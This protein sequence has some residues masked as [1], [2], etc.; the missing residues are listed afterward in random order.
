MLF[1]GSAS[2]LGAGD[3]NTVTRFTVALTGGPVDLSQANHSVTATVTA[4]S[5]CD[6]IVNS[7]KGPASLKASGTSTD[8]SFASEGAAGIDTEKLSFKQGIATPTLTPDQDAL[9]VKLTATDDGNAAIT[10]SSVSFNVFDDITDCGQQN[11]NGAIGDTKG[12]GGTNVSVEIPGTLDGFLGLSLSDPTLTAEDC[13]GAPAD[14]SRFG[15]AYIIAPP[16]DLDEETTYTATVR[17]NK[18]QVPGTG[19]SNFVHC[20][21]SPT[22]NPTTGQTELVYKIVQPCVNQIADQVPKCILDQRRN[23]AG[24]LMVTFLLGPGPSD[25][26]GTGMS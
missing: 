8:G 21:A 15:Q 3:C 24:D 5:S 10:G 14:A 4:L 9:G 11:C 16:S 1:G 2:S 6:T 20:M 18:K 25:P 13:E 19:V 22:V 17:F 7:Y 23:N 12:P 26:G